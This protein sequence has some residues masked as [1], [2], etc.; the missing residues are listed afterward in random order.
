[1]TIK[2]DG[3]KSVAQLTDLIK[4]AESL[5]VDNLTRTD[6]INDVY[7]W[8]SDLLIR[9]RYRFLTKREKG[10]VRRYLHLYSGYTMSHV[11]TLIGRYRN[12]GRIVRAQRTQPQYERVYTYKDIALLAEVADA[13]SHQNGKALKEV[14]RGMY[15]VYGDVR[16]ERLRRISVAHLYNLKKTPAFRKESLSYTKTRPVAVNIGERKKPYPQGKPGFLRV[17]SVHQGDLDKEKGVYHVNLVDEVT[18]DEVVVCVEGISEQFLKPALEEALA[19]FPFKILNFH[20][21]N[22]SEY[23]NKVVAKLLQKLFIH[24]TKSRSRKSNDNALA[25]G[26]NAAVV[27]KHMGHMHIPKKHAS[28]INGF[29]HEHLN[30]FLRFHR[31]CAFPDEIV[32]EKG[33]VRKVY[34]T[35]LTP[36][37]KLLSLHQAEEYL[38]DGITK[39]SL[40]KEATRCTHLEVAQNMQRAKQKLF[41]S[42]RKTV[43]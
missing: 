9:L 14:C 13:Y 40:H 39:E 31:F 21:D 11:D 6:G 30:P 28:A 12:T 24:Q 3:I 36:V 5:G 4:A 26:K 7:A 17:D 27:R 32:D 10:V 38:K 35:Y 34:R 20:S 29:Y 43:L 23:I 25:E 37:Q 19:Q 22:G 8:M 1:M 41:A 2:N 16:F 42:F 33:K 15:T 18:Q